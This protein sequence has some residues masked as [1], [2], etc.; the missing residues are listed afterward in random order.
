MRPEKTQ[1]KG[2]KFQKPEQSPR[3]KPGVKP[4]NCTIS[5]VKGTKSVL[6][7]SGYERA[8]IK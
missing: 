5:Q 4:A 6:L 8:R 2:E 7:G 1:A 3:R